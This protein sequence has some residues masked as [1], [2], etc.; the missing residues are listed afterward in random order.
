MVTTRAQA[1]RQESLARG[2]RA[3]YNEWISRLQSHGQRFARAKWPR[4]YKTSD[5]T[6]RHRKPDSQPKT[7]RVTSYTRRI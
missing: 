2:E 4:Q 3:R 7:T 6:K 5:L 1:S